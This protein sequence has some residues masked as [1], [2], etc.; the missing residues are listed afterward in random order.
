[1]K[2]DA[3]GP[4]LLEAFASTTCGNGELAF[5]W[6]GQH[7]FVLKMAGKLILVDP[8]LTAMKARRVPPLFSAEDTVDADLIVGSHDHADHIDRPVWPALAKSSPRASFLVPDLLRLGLAEDLA[9]PA[10]RLV[11]FDDGTTAEFD[12]LRITAIPAAHEL[13]DQD[14]ETGRYPYLGFVFEAEG[15]V[16]YFAGDTCIYEGLVTRLRRWEIDLALLP[17]NGRDA[18]RLRRNCIGN[19][20]Y[21]EAVDLAGT[22]GC[23]CVVPTHYDMFEGNLANVEDFCEYLSVKFP[24][25]EAIVPG[26]GQTRRLQRTER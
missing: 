17:I 2:I 7:S 8:F 3:Q 24:A 15:L 25:V 22:L 9:I 26:Y 21:Q 23:R 20:T 11:G 6:L 4:A 1:M 19:M 10:N 13:L 16:V 14:P 5:W 12:G 18:A